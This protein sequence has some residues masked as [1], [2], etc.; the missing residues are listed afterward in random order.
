[1]YVQSH[2]LL[3]ADVFKNFQNIYFEIYGLYPSKFLSA[4]GLALKVA[5]KNTKIKLDDLNGI[6]VLLMVRKGI[7][8]GIC[9]FIYRY[10]KDNE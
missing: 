1:M 10:A 5:L 8:R 4:T 9:Q 6:N 3:L 2:T 7:R